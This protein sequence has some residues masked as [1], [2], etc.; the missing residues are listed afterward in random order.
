MSGTDVR[1]LLLVEDDPNDVHFFRRG[2]EKAGLDGSLQV[3]QDGEVAV[4]YIEGRGRY[5][6]RALHPLPALIVLD[7]KLPRKG[8]LEVLR[9]LRKDSRFKGIPVIILTSSTEPSDVAAAR[10]LGVTDYRVKSSDF[11]ETCDLVRSIGL[12]WAKLT[13][14]VDRLRQAASKDLPKHP[15]PPTSASV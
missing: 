11:Q 3:A 4:D 6:N 15:P 13:E 5:E 2:L 9:W 8:G 7:L 14:N 1:A 12:V 10:A